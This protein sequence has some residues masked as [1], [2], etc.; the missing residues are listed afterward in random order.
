MIPYTDLCLTLTPQQEALKGGSS[1]CTRVLRP[2]AMALDQVP[3]PQ[4][5]ID[6]GSLLWTTLKAAYA[7]G[8]HTA[9]VLASTVD[10]AARVGLASGPRRTRMGQRGLCGQ[11]RRGRI[12]LFVGGR[13]WKCG[14]D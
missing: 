11:H 14:I 1:I 7:Q 4:Q 8:F 5:V 13:G 2:A 3:N 6:L 12:S 9:L 10:W